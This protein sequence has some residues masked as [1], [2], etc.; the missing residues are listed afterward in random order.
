MCDACG[1]IQ[2]GNPSGGH[3]TGSNSASSSSGLKA[4]TPISN[5]DDGEGLHDPSNAADANS[6]AGHTAGKPAFIGEG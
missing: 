6:F 3:F 2:F 4:T 1:G 5:K